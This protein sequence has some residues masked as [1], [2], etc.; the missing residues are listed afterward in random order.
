MEN[1]NKIICI[2]FSDLELEIRVKGFEK[3]QLDVAQTKGKQDGSS[4]VVHDRK[5]WLVRI[6]NPLQSAVSEMDALVQKR[7]NPVSA[8]EQ[9]V[10]TEEY[11]RTETEAIGR[12]LDDAEV[13]IGRCRSA[14]EGLEPNI[15]KV[16]SAMVV[17]IV[18]SSIGVFDGLITYES[19]SACGMGFAQALA[20]SGIL[21]LAIGVG[22]HFL[23]EFALRAGTYWAIA[24][25]LAVGFSLVA[26]LFYCI[27]D[28]RYQA[29]VPVDMHDYTELVSYTYTG[30]SSLSI[31]F[32]SWIAFVGC[33]LSALL[34]WLTPQERE[35]LRTYRKRKRDL[36]VI[37]SDY[38]NIKL[39][40]ANITTTCKA[41]IY[42]LTQQCE[43]ALSYKKQVSAI[44]KKA[45]TRYEEVYI[46]YRNCGIVPDYFGSY[47]GTDFQII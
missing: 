19:V 31:G 24:L 41:E 12:E 25:R 3:E 42:D 9:K 8:V 11:L 26:I 39:R 21:T 10:R 5:H 38:K 27:G 20:Y 14:L 37:V 4:K 28:I 34:F 13:H 35:Q 22:H 36:K 45:L 7:L 2:G 30:M 29:T 44:A 18:A 1:K 32:I 17:F 43:L 47:M 46:Q 16:I 15:T 23:A 33:T 6:V 40:L